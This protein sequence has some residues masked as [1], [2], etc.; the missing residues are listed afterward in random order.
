[1][2]KNSSDAETTVFA[3]LSYIKLLKEADF[4]DRHTTLLNLARPSMVITGDWSIPDL[5]YF[6]YC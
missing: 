5:P 4:V 6:R 2:N 1:M 3:S